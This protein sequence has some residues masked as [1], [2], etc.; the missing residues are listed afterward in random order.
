[1]ESKVVLD[2]NI[3]VAAGFN[4]ASHSARLLDLIR[5]NEISLVWNEATRRESRRVLDQIPPINWEEVEDIFT[6]ENE[7]K[8]TTRP[9]DFGMV[10]DPDDRKF[11]ALAAASGAILVSNDDHLLSVR[12][13]LTV[14][15]L[16]PAE[17]FA[18]T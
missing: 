1:M 12:H 7:F 8:G 16:T 11:A 17:L 14:Q 3:L 10:A 6:P 5:K 13:R 18:Q 4:P 2:T 9:E 15:V